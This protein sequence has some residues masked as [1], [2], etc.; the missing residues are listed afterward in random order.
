MEFIKSLIKNKRL[1]YQLGKNDFKNRF[2]G[3]SLGAIWGFVSPFVFILREI[4][5]AELCR[6]IC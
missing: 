6:I 4:R 1:V 2:A 5:L 3:T